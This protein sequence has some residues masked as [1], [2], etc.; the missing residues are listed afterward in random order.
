MQKPIF[1]IASLVLIGCTKAITY[2]QIEPPSVQLRDDQRNILFISRYDSANVDFNQKKKVEV[3]RE[4][5]KKLVTGISEGF[6]ST[7][8]V[9]WRDSITVPL[10]RST[11]FLQKDTIRLICEKYKT[12][13][14]L[15]LENFQMDRV[16]EMEVTEKDDGSKKR[17]AHYTVQVS[18]PMSLYAS[19][20]SLINSA[21][22]QGEE[23]LDSRSVLSGLFS[24][25]PSMG[26][27]ED[28][29]YP[30][31]TNLGLHYADNYQ[32]HLVAVNSFL[33]T[34]KK[35]GSIKTYI[36]T[37]DW[38]RAR[39]NLTQLVNT[40]T[41]PDIKAHAA[42]NLYVINMILKDWDEAKK[43]SSDHVN[44]PEYDLD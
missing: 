8:V 13:M 24:V 21:P 38:L 33:Y 19:D 7:F 29:I 11:R 1:L 31:L 34:S 42:H 25:G 2:Y 26:N 10:P 23:R 15:V 20:G 4:G 40:S 9:T 32:S 22:I 14:L 43:W 5:Y 44:L 3:Y 27:Q 41:D 16:Q 35:L 28:V 12:P 37:K 39:Q 6:D 36:K 30:L 18:V 17:T